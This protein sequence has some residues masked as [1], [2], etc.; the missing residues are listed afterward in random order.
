[1]HDSRTLHS[2]LVHRA[3]SAGGQRS[4]TE[5]D[6]VANASTLFGSLRSSGSSCRCLFIDRSRRK[7]AAYLRHPALAS[8]AAFG[9]RIYTIRLEGRFPCVALPSVCGAWSPGM[10]GE[11][12][13]RVRLFPRL[14]TYPAQK[15]LPGIP[16]AVVSHGRI[17]DEAVCP[18]SLNCTGRSSPRLSD[19]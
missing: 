7:V 9:V 5:Q 11:R 18:L 16:C 2:P 15:L 4:N 14:P 8:R 3:T 12:F 1:M 17:Q 13:W 19:S 6:V 10:V